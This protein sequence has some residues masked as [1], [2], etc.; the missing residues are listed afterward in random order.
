MQDSN[1]YQ[2]YIFKEQRRDRKKVR[3]NKEHE[4]IKVTGTKKTKNK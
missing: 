3:N 4:I 1:S 2:K